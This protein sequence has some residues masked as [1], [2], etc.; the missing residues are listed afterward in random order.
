MRE[1]VRS[2]LK[3]RKALDWFKL[4]G[5]IRL[6]PAVKLEIKKKKSGKA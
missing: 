3:I 5:Q 6:Q 4:T 2:N 1:S